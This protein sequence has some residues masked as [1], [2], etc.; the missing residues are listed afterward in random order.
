MT[1]EQQLV[2]LCSE[3]G[4][5]NLSIGVSIRPDGSHYFG[6]YAHRDGQCGSSSLLRDS[7]S[8]STG[9]AITAVLA[10]CGQPLIAVPELQAADGYCPGYCALGE[11]HNGPCP[12]AEAA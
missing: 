10:K 1:L 4:L 7:I 6:S 3:H 12:R 8:S 5:N 2:A 11:E 9:E